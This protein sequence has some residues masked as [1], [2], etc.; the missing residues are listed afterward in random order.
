MFKERDMLKTL[1][2]KRRKAAPKDEG[3]TLIE[4]LVTMAI[5]AI[6]VAGVA[7]AVLPETGKA[8]TIRAC[9]AYTA[10]R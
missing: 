5:I 3:F 2:E 6:M 9:Q 1:I 4:V 10:K 7:V 8:Q